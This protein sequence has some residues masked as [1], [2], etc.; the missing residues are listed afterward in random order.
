MACKVA[1]EAGYE[2]LWIDACCIDKSSSAELAEAINSMYEWYRLSDMC[3]ALL[4]DVPD[5][6]DP[7]S[8]MSRF[9]FWRSR[10]HRRGW[11]LQELIAPKRVVFLTKTWRFLGTKMALAKELQMCTGVDCDILT[12][13]AAV[14]SVSVSRRMSWAASRETTRVEDQAYSLLGIFGVHM[15][16]IY[17]EGVNAFF[18][19]QEEI[20]RKVPDQTIFAWS[21]RKSWPALLAPSPEIF[22]NSRYLR[23][24][25]PA[26]FASRLGINIEDVPPLHAVVTPQGV[27]MKLLCLDLH[28]FPDAVD[29]IADLWEPFPPTYTC[30]DCMRLPRAHLLAFL[31]CQNG[32]DDLLALPLCHPRPGVETGL[33]VAPQVY[34]PHIHLQINLQRVVNVTQENVDQLLERWSV[35]AVDVSI[36]HHQWPL[37]SYTPPRHRIKR[38]GHLL[39]WPE[40]TYVTSAVDFELSPDSA[41]DLKQL[42]FY[43]SPL[44]CSQSHRAIDLSFML[45]SQSIYRPWTTDLP[46]QKVAINIALMQADPRLAILDAHFSATNFTFGSPGEATADTPDSGFDIPPSFLLDTVSGARIPE[47]KFMTACNLC[48][49][50]LHGLACADFTVYAGSAASTEAKDGATCIRRLK[51]YLEHPAEPRKGL[52]IAVELSDV[53]LIYTKKPDDPIRTA[54]PLRSKIGPSSRSEITNGEPTVQQLS[55]TVEMLRNENS[56]LKQQLSSQNTQLAAVLER[57][58]NLERL[59]HAST[60]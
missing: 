21:Y 16:P 30:I 10:W 11:T 56:E 6:K 23:T 47:G 41:K 14:D 27:H 15:A 55:D 1:R 4:V 34:C 29:A 20:L 45:Y 2:I 33:Y 42:G 58:A 7:T 5:S 44:Q 53:N 40:D 60:S 31:R 36:L 24:I 43:M 54:T 32:N 50:P 12:G 52:R 39:F 51:V 19:L 3:Y 18:R 59:A 46:R 8:D 49:E 26:D 28:R 17:G 57:L 48:L 25:S 9:T 22:G 13:H 35:S 38:P 37:D